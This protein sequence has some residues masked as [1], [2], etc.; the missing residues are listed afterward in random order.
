MATRTDLSSFN[1]YVWYSAPDSS[2]N[3]AIA[4]YDSEF[5]GM[6]LV[7]LT[8][9]QTVKFS[10]P[11]SE[12]SLLQ[13]HL[14]SLIFFTKNGGGR[15]W[16][17]SVVSISSTSWG[18]LLKG[19]VVKKGDSVSLFAVLFVVLFCMVSVFSW[20]GG[21][22]SVGLESS[23]DESV[24][25]VIFGR[26]TGFRRRLFFFLLVL[27]DGDEFGVTVECPLLLFAANCMW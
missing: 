20:A 9:L 26:S 18:R 15:G 2:R 16:R 4:R 14:I 25:S 27:V 1:W 6:I 22:V 3:L 8:L 17:A 21:M 7:S 11:M 23:L 13:R 12:V 19:F 24:W 5:D 10:F